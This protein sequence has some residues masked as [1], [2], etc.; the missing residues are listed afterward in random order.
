MAID[1]STGKDIWRIV[2]PTEARDET[3][4]AYTTPIPITNDGKTEIALLG[5]DAV[6]GHDPETGK[7]L[8]RV[9]GWNPNTH[10]PLAHCADADANRRFIS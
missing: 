3:K 1:A 2:R 8:W 10:R 5:G 7:E 6:T 4:E 9:E